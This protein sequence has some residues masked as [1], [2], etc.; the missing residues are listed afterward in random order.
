MGASLR[1][2]QNCIH[3]L[4]NVVLLLARWSIFRMNTE[5]NSLFS[6]QFLE[7]SPSIRTECNMRQKVYLLFKNA[8]DSKNFVTKYFLRN[9]MCVLLIE[10]AFQKSSVE[11][12]LKY[13]FAHSVI[14]KNL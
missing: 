6:T 2:L 9:R 14:I 5:E 13:T 1:L 3:H 11:I 12:Y 7:C 10:I 8:H 4:K